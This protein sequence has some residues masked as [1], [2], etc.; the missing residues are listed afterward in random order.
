MI[1]RVAQ[2]VL[3]LIT[4]A[5][6]VGEGVDLTYSQATVRGVPSLILRR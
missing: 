6:C 3:L 4:L 1:R 5:A 2:P